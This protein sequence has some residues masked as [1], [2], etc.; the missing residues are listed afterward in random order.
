M[1]LSWENVVDVLEKISVAMKAFPHMQPI[2]LLD[3]APCHTH[4]E[5]IAK[6]NA[7]GIWLCYVPA[8]MTSMLQPLDVCCFGSYKARLRRAFQAVETQARLERAAW[9]L[10]LAQIVKEYWR[11]CKWKPAFER[12]GV[13]TGPLAEAL[14]R[15]LRR[16]ACPRKVPD[17]PPSS[18][19][20]KAVLPKGH[21]CVWSSVFLL[22]A[23]LEGIELPD[24]L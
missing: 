7:T 16:L 3:C 12:V 17:G 10:A 15:Q 4:W 24:L 19:D 23:D 1:E 14:T 2:L 11:G 6:G 20:L 21:R 13:H 22:P 8:R 9:A 18:L 5:V